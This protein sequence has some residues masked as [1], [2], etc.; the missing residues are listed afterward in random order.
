MMFGNEREEPA[1][2]QR[3]PRVGG[4]HLHGLHALAQLDVLVA[5]RL[6]RAQARVV[7]AHLD[8][9]AQSLAAEDVAGPAAHVALLDERLEAAAKVDRFR[10]SVRPEHVTE[11]L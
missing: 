1:P 2:S 7:D 6:V 3:V 8:E 11:V 4:L 9:P 10:R 5:A